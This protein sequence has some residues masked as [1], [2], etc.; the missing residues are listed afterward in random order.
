[1]NKLV[2]RQFEQQKERKMANHRK[3]ILPLSGDP[4]TWGHIDLIQRAGT[5]CEHLL[6]AVLH[7][8]SKDGSHV[9]D[10]EERIEHV[11]KAIKDFC[12]GVKAT[13]VVSEQG[14]TDVFI[15][16]NCDV[17]YRG[18]RDQHDRDY[19][20]QQLIYHEMVL[21][22]IKDRTII[23]E[24]DPKLKHVQST[25]ARNFAG[26]H[27]DATA[28]VPMFVQARLWRKIHKQKVIGVT[29][30]PGVGKTTLIQ[31]ALKLIREDKLP[32]HHV[33]L[34]KLM[35]DLLA[36]DSPGAKALKARLE[37]HSKKESL[38]E[39][40]QTL[41][42][43]HFSRVYR[44]ELKGRSGIVFVESSYLAEDGLFHWTNNNSVVIT[45]KEL[46][47]PDNSQRE[48][49]EAWEPERKLEAYKAAA[50][51]DKYGL[52]FSLENTKTGSNECL[53]AI[54]L[55]KAKSRGL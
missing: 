1:V 40:L 31:A 38:P 26:Q 55:A 32:A 18:A 52:V 15:R 11:K 21:P 41:L 20:N 28:L 42:F 5:E 27:L 36:E 46:L 51:K 43:A 3:G 29:G 19:E 4:I 17:V 10:E 54:V 30:L 16:E 25:V 50:E 37:T 13:V 45:S 22:G 6:V 35:E 49:G 9:I 48:R 7:N 23:L 34:N 8:P 14:L 53:G 24:A 33:D 12:P 47:P 44:Q 39:D 2:L